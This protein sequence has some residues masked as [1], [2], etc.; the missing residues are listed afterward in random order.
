MAEDEIMTFKNPDFTDISKTLL[1]ASNIAV[2]GISDNPMR[3][4]YQIAEYLKEHGYH[5]FPVNPKY[6]TVLDLKCYPGLADIDQKIDIVNIFRQPEYVLP[7]VEAAIPLKPAVIWM[8]LGV[9]NEPAAALAEQNG[10]M[11]VMDR[12]IKIEHRRL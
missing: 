3:P 11:V 6:D 9:I 7:I 5:I 2:V 1:T 10:I 4:S 8:Q 12:C